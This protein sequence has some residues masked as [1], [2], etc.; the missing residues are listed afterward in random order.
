MTRILQSLGAEESSEKTIPPTIRL[1]FLGNTLDSSS[2]TLEV[3][4]H[5]KQELLTLI[6]K[7]L[8]KDR[9][10]LKELQ[11]LI[12]KLSFVTN[13]IRPGRIFI[14]R[15]LGI[16]RQMPQTGKC[17]LQK[18]IIDDLLWWKHYLPGFNVVSILWLQDCMQIDKWLETM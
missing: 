8:C 11:S 12:G 18:E 7:W 1:E 3:S 2:M 5:C 13:C 6:E 10:S 4:V 17:E 14:S 16:L 15:L 9:F